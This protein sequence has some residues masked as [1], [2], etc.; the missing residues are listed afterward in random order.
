M[1]CA[2]CYCI[3][4]YT[5]APLTGQRNAH[6]QPSAHPCRF[7]LVEEP[8]VTGIPAF[9]QHSTYGYYAVLP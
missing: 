9:T 8:D 1:I 2:A 3:T 6:L 7:V 5:N 4:V